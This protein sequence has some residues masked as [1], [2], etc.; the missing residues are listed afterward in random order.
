MNKFVMVPLVA[1]AFA[2]AGCQEVRP[3]SDQVQRQQQ[4]AIAMQATMSVGMPAIVNFAEKRQLTDIYELRD[5][6]VPTYTYLYDMNGKIGEKLCDSVGFGISAATQYTNP[7]KI[8]WRSSNSGYASGVLPQADPN[9]LFSPASAE[10]T[11]VL[12]KVPGSDKVM[13]QYIEP[14]VIVLTYPK[15]NRK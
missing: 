5:K 11:W 4:E 2:L 1:G 3:T 14:R 13:P 7:Q 9:G 12:C 10:G 6:L 8:E 15:E